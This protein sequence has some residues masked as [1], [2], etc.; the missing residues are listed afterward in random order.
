MCDDTYGT[1]PLVRNYQSTCTIDVVTKITTK[2]A[3]ITFSANDT[4]RSFRVTVKKIRHGLGLVG[5]SLLNLA[6]Y[7]L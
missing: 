2:L 5:T 3:H 4:K 1:S 7:F 6:T